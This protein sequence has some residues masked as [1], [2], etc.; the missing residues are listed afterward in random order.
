[1]AT[2][3]QHI[4]GLTQID[5][6]AS[7]APT[8]DELTEI[9]KE[10]LIHTVNTIT[11][12][13]PEELPKFTETTNST[14]NVTKQ[15]KVLS[16][17]REHNSQTILRPCTPIN[18]SLRTEAADI[19]SLHYR[20]KYNP[21]YYEL[22]NTLFCVPAP[23]DTTDNDLVVT[24]V[25]Y[26]TG[27]VATDN[28]NAGAVLYFPTD[29]EYL[30]GLYGAAMACNAQANNINNNMPTAPTAPIS[31][32]FS[33]PEVNLPELPIFNIE[34]PDFKTADIDATIRKEDLD[35][36]D[37]YFD[38]F[39][40]NVESYTKKF[41]NEVKIYENELEIFKS[42]LENLT[43]DADRKTQVETSEYQ[44]QLELYKNELQFF[45][46][47]LQEA[48]AQYKWYTSQYVTFMSQYN[49]ALG[50]KFKQPQQQQ[51][52]PKKRRKEGE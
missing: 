23:N 5:I 7:S 11:T 41:D 17:T 43:K 18:P 29:Y 51:G 14:S 37:K 26:D 45:Q 2:F 46:T 3:E 22:N 49:Q 33:N 12:L 50:I 36:V 20:S 25:K 52:E 40:K 48:A 38:L 34:S 31:P 10:G 1:M 21:A 30:L 47:D 42:D 35:K 39:D 19:D 9:L 16:I 6:T 8:I 13:K 28:Y 44:G 4:E 32:N 24:Q 15:G 27:L